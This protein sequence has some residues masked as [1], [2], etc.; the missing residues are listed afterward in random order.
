MIKKPFHIKSLEMNKI[1]YLEPY[2]FVWYIK[3]KGIIYNSLTH[4]GFEFQNYGL[5]SKK[6]SE[7]TDLNNMY[8][9]EISE[10]ELLDHNLKRFI[11]KVQTIN[12]GGLIKISNTNRKPIIIPPKIKLMNNFE[13]AEK[14]SNLGKEIKTYIHEISI[15]INGECNLNCSFCDKYYKQFLCCTK[16]KSELSTEA[17][18]DFYKAVQ[19][20]SLNTINILGANIFNYS[21]IQTFINKLDN[22]NAI[23]VYYCHYQ[24]LLSNH[25]ILNKLNKNKNRLKILINFPLAENFYDNIYLLVIDQIDTEWQFVISSN[26]EYVQA[27]RIIEKFKFDKYEFISFYT[28]KNYSFFQKNVFLTKRDILF[29]R[30]NKRQVFAQEIINTFD[31]GKLILF[32]N[33]DVYAN[34]NMAPIG[35]IRSKINEIVFNELNSGSSWRR[36]RKNIEPCNNCVFML[37]CPSPSNYELA[38]GKSNLCKIK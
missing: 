16:S 29:S 26:E 1:F 13:D 22:L 35:N 30:I 4:K 10:N 34:I 3:E 17:I 21:N 28:G 8:C 7:F 37:L 5:I 38:I 31:F 14:S 18:F 19:N 32:S 25:L 15:Y 11:L 24:N 12:A 33:E 9:I 36:T 6:V 27:K 23:K 2:T 20:R